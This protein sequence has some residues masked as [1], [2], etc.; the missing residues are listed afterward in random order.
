MI[1]GLLL[2]VV[3]TI[4]FACVWNQNINN[5]LYVAFKNK[6]NWLV[7]GCYL[8][9]LFIMMYALKGLHVGYYKIANLIISQVIALF[10]THAVLTIQIVLLT[11]KVVVIKTIVI[12]M[13]RLLGI[14]SIIVILL[15]IIFAKVYSFLFPPY[16]LLHIYGDYTNNLRKKILF[17]RDRYSIEKDIY[18]GEKPEIIEEQILKYDG[19]VLNDIPTSNKNELLKFCFDH[20]IRVYF[21]PKISDIFIKMSEEINIFDTPLF[22]CKNVGLTFEQRLVKRVMDILISGI[23][24]IIALP[25][26]FVTALAVKLE[27]GGPV[28]YSQKRCTING[29]VFT[30]YK[31]RSMKV[32][33]EKLGG[34]QLAKKND[35]RITK[36]GR[37][38][39]ATRLDELPQLFNVLKGDMSFVGPRPERPEFVEKNCKEI[40]EFSY[41]MKVKAGLT[42]YAQ[43]YGKYNTGFLD[44]LKLDLI[45][46]EKYS[47][48]LD[49]QIILMTLKVILMKESAEGLEE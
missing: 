39:R 18:F 11:G 2:V 34:A 10:C 5:L 14:N 42:G 12:N 13:L 44:K 6:G 37:I 9:V 26:M 41:R 29:R 25:F 24:L 21:V 15:T 43:V 1:T 28:L 47:V 20:R 3:P 38:I 48:I 30:L 19:V 49:I 36:V 4:F 45:Y 33:A 35:D 8:F 27:D 7:V 46:I 40:P 32:K 31:F 17:R 22:L 23:V 16:R